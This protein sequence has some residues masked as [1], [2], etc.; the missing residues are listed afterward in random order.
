MKTR[1]EGAKTNGHEKA[2]GGT[3]GGKPEESKIRIMSNHRNRGAGIKNGKELA[4]R[5]SA[6]REK[7]IN[8][9]MVLSRVNST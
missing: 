7:E 9:C 6:L 8:T 3:K 2:Q 5:L 1:R 4:D